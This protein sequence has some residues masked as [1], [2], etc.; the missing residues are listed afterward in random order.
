M[1]RFLQVKF[2]PDTWAVQK[3][4]MKFSFIMCGRRLNIGLM[5]LKPLVLALNFFS[6]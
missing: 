4:I 6:D 3:L 2:V 1:G 5:F